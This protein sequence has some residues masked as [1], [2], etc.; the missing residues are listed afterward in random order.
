MKYKKQPS[1]FVVVLNY[2]GKEVLKDCLSSIYQSNYPKFEVVVIDNGSRDGSMEDAKN[3]FSKAHFIKNFQNM[4]YAKG[5]NVGI[6]FALERFA[7]YVLVLNNDA[8]LKT[9]TLSELLNEAEK[10]PLPSVFNPVILNTDEKSV[11]FSGG[12]I[13]WLKIKTV[14]LRKISSNNP[15]RTQYCTGCAMFVSKDVFKKIGLFDERYFL[16]YEDA[17]FSVRAKRAGFDLFIC[18][19]AK[20]IHHEQSS[21]KNKSK[22]YWLILSGLLFFYLNSNF[23]QKKWLIFHLQLRKLKNAYFLM[24]GKCPIAPQVKKAYMDFER[25]I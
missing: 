15:F 22:N 20:V 14:H 12:Q 25:L 8:C 7:D 10:R 4:G 24:N 1:V 21:I 5:N 2:N 9:N 6:R 19:S 18:P 17:D 11:W 23:F 3:I 16:Y 13:K